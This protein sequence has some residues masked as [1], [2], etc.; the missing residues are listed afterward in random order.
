MND[1]ILVIKETLRFMDIPFTVFGFTLTVK[2]L[3][4]MFSL[5]GLAFYL[6]GRLLD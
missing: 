6:L 3:F 2:S 4:I 5:L 1:Y